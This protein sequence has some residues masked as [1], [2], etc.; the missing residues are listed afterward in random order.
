MFNS[1]CLLLYY[2]FDY[3]NRIEI[4]NRFRYFISLLLLRITYVLLLLK[5]TY[6]LYIQKSKPHFQKLPHIIIFKDRLFDNKIVRYLKLNICVINKKYL[7]NI[8]NC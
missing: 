2:P 3:F 4:L 8:F 5:I 6:V 7:S 1:F